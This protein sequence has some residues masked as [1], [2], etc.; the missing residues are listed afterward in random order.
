MSI[1]SP[2]RVI[3]FTGNRNVYPD[4]I[5]ASKSVLYH[6]AAD[7]IF[8]LTEDNE[9]PDNLPINVINVNMSDQKYLSKDSPNFNTPWSYFTMM[10]IA[11]P[12][13]Y[14]GRA[15]VLDVDTIVLSD[16]H[17]LWALP[18]APIYMAKEIGR[19]YTYYNSGVMLMNASTMRQY[20]GTIFEKLNTKYYQFNE[21]DAINEVM[22][23]N[24]AE[25]PPEFN[26]SNWTVKNNKPPQIVHY[27]AMKNWHN[28]PLWKHYAEMTWDEA[29]TKKM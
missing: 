12:Y 8:F 15:L 11:V 13:L 21:Q 14:S 27:A 5:A 24:I 4:M 20:V 17:E 19:S 18:D 7:W 28:E 1:S 29:K 2:S 6:K 10:K 23:A 16:L 26:V 9:F 3:V 22:S 25:L